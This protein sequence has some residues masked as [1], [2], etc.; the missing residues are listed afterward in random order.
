MNSWF[1][2]NASQKE[3]VFPG[4]SGS[5]YLNN[6]YSVTRA[7]FFLLYVDCSNSQPF[8]ELAL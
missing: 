4:D 7:T 2:K 8:S 6:N 5:I 1:W 3:A